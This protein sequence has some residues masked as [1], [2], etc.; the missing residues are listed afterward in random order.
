[1]KLTTTFAFAGIGMASAVLAVRSFVPAGA[2]EVVVARPPR[3]LESAAAVATVAPPGASGARLSAP[4][5]VA[6][7]AVLGRGA[8]V[9]G[10]GGEVFALVRAVGGSGAPASVRAPVSLALVVDRS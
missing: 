3:V 10:E 1:M 5:T 8:V 7:E 9:R 4:G 2:P 6:L